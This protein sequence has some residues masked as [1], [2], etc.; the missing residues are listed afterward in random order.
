M[1]YLWRF[2]ICILCFAQLSPIVSKELEKGYSVKIDSCTADSLVKGEKDKP[3][4]DKTVV[5]DADEDGMFGHFVYGLL[6]TVEGSI[7]VFSEARID[8]GRDDGAHHLVM[9]RSTDKGKSFSRSTIVVESKDGQSWAN[10][11]PIQ[12][13]QTGNL[14]LFYALNEQNV[15]SRVFYMKSHNDGISWSSPSEITSLFN[16]NDYDWTFHLPGP[17]HGTQLKNGR[18]LIPVWHRKSIAY[19]PHDRLYGVNCIYSDD[20]G[21]TWLVGSN[22]PVGELN[23]SQLIEKENGDILLIGRTHT[24]KDGSWQAKVHSKDGGITWTTTLEYDYDLQ[25]R[26]CDIGLIW[27]ENPAILLASLPTHPQRRADLTIMWSQD[28][29]ETWKYGRLLEEGPATYSDLAVLPDGTII[30]LYGHGRGKN[31]HIPDK[32][33]VARFNMEWLQMSVD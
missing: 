31:S 29:G 2:C 19:S 11:T 14:F 3:M 27:T 5:W 17:G 12:D 24:G 33:S 25:G 20:G 6:T 16:H 28:E 4:C 8:D 10:P 13:K 32:V 30:C 7:L 23:E 18:L 1:L 21:Q 15:S 22:T 26:V 9:K